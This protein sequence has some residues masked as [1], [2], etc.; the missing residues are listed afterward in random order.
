MPYRNQPT[1]APTSKVQAAAAV[2]ALGTIAVWAMDQ[3]FGVTLTPEVAAAIVTVA[4]FAASY[5]MP[6]RFE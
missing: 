2:G 6:E 1:L 4:M 3:F 5:L